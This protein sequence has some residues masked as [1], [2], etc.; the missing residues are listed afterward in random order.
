ML[1]MHAPASAL[2]SALFKPQRNASAW[3]AASV[4]FAA[5]MGTALHAETVWLETLDLA[6]CQQDWGKPAAARTVDGRPITV[7]G[8]KYEHGFGTHA[9]SSLYIELQGGAEKFAAV[10]GVDD[11]VKGNQEGTVIFQVL[12]DNKPLWSSGPVKASQPGKP[13]ELDIKGVKVLALLVNADGDSINY[14]HADWAGA[15]LEVNGAKP[16]TVALPPMPPSEAVVLTPKPPATPRINGAKV[17]GVRPGH[18]FLFTI[19]ATG[20]R[21]MQ[22]AAEKLPAGLSLDPVAGRITGV[23]KEKGEYTI[24]L[25]A[26]NALG[27]VD[28]KLRVTVGDTIALTPPLGWNSWN[29]FASAV[30]DA[31]VRSAADAMVSSGLINHGWT[32][33]NI[34]DCWEAGRD[35]DGFIECNHKFPDMKALGAYIHGLGLKFGIYSSPG[36]KTC[37]GFTASYQHEDK[38]ALRYAQWGVDY[39]KYDW[40]SYGSVAREITAQRYASALPDQA[41]TVKGLIEQKAKLG[42]NRKRTPEQ[43]RELKKVSGELNELL[44]KLDPVQKS[45]IDLEIL[46]EPYKVFRASLDKVDRDIVFS[47]CQYGMG[48]VWEWGQKLGGNSWRTTG[49]ITDTWSSMAGIGFSQA[50]HEVYAGPGHWNDPDMLVVGHVGW[51]PRLHPTRLTPDEQYTHIS[52][53]SLLASPLLI[54]CDMAQMDEFTQSLLTNDEV[55]DISQDSL[56][57]QAARVQQQKGGVEVWAKEL[58]D[59]SK[60]VG[61]FNRKTTPMTIAALWESLGIKGRQIVRDVWRQKDL[62]SFDGKFE[63]TVAPHGVVL[64]RVRP[65]GA[66]R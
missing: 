29:C 34:D 18:P 37:A 26:K 14:L 6:K 27:A 30:D 43:E 23:L 4:A 57:K 38:D 21:P 63:T 1:S 59:G 5:L 56:G 55:L 19:A 16:Q 40:C 58:E 36:P 45:R 20:D 12:G 61:L 47:Y 52:L 3:I 7:G 60:A 48:N 49:D 8:Q 62:G 9:N 33:V 10:V 46:Q 32:Y 39:V 64:V 17:F 2:S 65:E 13:I 11:E 66:G 44:Q 42:A 24:D 41:G 25:H 51:G 35:K 54:G 31:K 28:R 50:G 15:R 53:W 22:F